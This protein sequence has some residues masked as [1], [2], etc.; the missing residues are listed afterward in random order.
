MIFSRAALRNRTNTLDARAANDSSS[1]R[2][3]LDRHVRLPVVDSPVREG[4]NSNS[5]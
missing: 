3:G 5:D 4:A 1:M 2:D